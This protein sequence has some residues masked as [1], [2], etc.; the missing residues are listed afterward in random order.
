[1][2][3]FRFELYKYDYLKQNNFDLYKKA[4]ASEFM[5]SVLEL[6]HY[7]SSDATDIKSIDSTCGVNGVRKCPVHQTVHLNEYLGFACQCDP[8]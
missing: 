1:M 2:H 5:Q 7:C 6:L 4:D 3:K 8:N